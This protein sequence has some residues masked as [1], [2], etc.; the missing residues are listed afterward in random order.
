M[1]N[2][3]V[4]LS[5]LATTVGV[6]ALV[7]DCVDKLGY[8][9]EPFRRMAADPQRITARLQSRPVKLALHVLTLATPL[10]RIKRRS[11]GY[12]MLGL[13][14]VDARSGGAP[15]RRQAFVRATAKRLWPVLCKQLLPTPKTPPLEQDRLPAEL[16]AVKVRFP[17]DPDARN[18]ALM[19]VYKD[20]QVDP[21]RSC[22]PLLARLPLLAAIDLPVFSRL[23]QSLPDRLAGTT[24]VRDP[25]SLL[26]N[27]FA[28]ATP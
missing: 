15:T 24:V 16:M 7:L 27:T 21:R 9:G 10:R 6:G 2:T 12:A 1:I 19:Q 26:K 17:D 11:L 14:L 28:R 23:R 18:H 8:D 20:R 13:R 3:A 22:M 25:Q 4:G 5:G